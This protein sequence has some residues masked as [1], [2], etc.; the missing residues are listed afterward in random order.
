[1]GNP[2]TQKYQVNGM[3][4]G[5]CASTVKN[6]LST[7]S[8]VTSVQIDVAKK[9]AEIVSSEALSVSTLQD[10]LKGTHYTIA[11]N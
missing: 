2:T 5:G 3:S 1:M 4:C 8:G 11:E 7:V 10:S 6:K 9:E